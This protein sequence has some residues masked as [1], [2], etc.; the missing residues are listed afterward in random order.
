[1]TLYII[2]KKCY[3]KYKKKD[4]KSI[5]ILKNENKIK[6]LFLLKENSTIV[7][8][9]LDFK[10]S[11]NNDLSVYLPIN[12]FTEM[13]IAKMNNTIINWDTLESKINKKGCI[14]KIFGINDC[15]KQLEFLGIYDSNNEEIL[16]FR[17]NL[18]RLK[19]ESYVPYK[20]LNNITLMKYKS[21][22]DK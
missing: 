4:N 13:A 16:Y 18:G 1:M 17:F 19:T 11:D 7:Y 14:L 6:Y 20:K 9:H 12:F 10:G 21:N 2:I 5:V 22:K 15:K 8:K 3:N